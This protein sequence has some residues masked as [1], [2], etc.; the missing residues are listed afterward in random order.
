MFNLNCVTTHQ[1]H[2]DQLRSV[3]KKKKKKRPSQPVLL[4]TDLVSSN[5]GQSHW[6]WYTILEGKD[7]HM[8][9]C[10]DKNW[11]K[12]L[13]IV[14]NIKFFAM[15]DNHTDD[16]LAGWTNTT[17]Y[18]D[19]YV[20]CTGKK[21]K[22][23]IFTRTLFSDCIFRLNC[24][25]SLVIR[26]FRE[27]SPSPPPKKKIKQISSYAVFKI[28]QSQG[29]SERGT[30]WIRSMELLATKNMNKFSWKMWS[31]PN[32]IV[33]ALHEDWPA[34]Q[35]CIHDTHADRND[36]ENK[37][38]NETKYLTDQHKVIKAIKIAIFMIAN[39]PGST[40]IQCQPRIHR[41]G[42]GKV[43]HPGSSDFT[44]IHNEQWAAYNLLTKCASDFNHTLFTI[45][46]L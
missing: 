36:F 30:K 29:F 10:F 5:Q 46:C 32:V 43:N 40:V 2:P 6:K 31:K 8:C 18:I 45:S 39:W 22:L 13:P 12:S 21:R 20:N 41:N 19:P 1:L 24:I 27:P 4:F 44:V 11:L 38:C 37:R 7:T 35:A 33:H 34:E 17:D 42:L 16:Q 23:R 15:Q 26:M 9:G 3:K 14:F 28:F 25:K